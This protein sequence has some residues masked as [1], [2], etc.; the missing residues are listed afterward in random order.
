MVLRSALLVLNRAK[1]CPRRPEGSSRENQLMKRF[2][3]LRRDGINFKLSKILKRSKI[4]KGKG[5]S[6]EYEP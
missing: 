6:P 1:E 5:E 2:E 3:Q 4:A